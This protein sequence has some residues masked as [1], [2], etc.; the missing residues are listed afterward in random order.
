MTVVRVNKK[1]ICIFIPAL[2]EASS[3]GKVIDGFREQGYEN[4]LVVDGHSTDGTVDVARAHEAKVLVQDGRGKGQAIQQTFSTVSEDYI[5]MMDGDMTY[6]PSEVGLVLAPVLEGEADHVIGNRFANYQ[7]GAFTRLNLLGNRI[8]NRMFGLAHGVWLNDILSGYRAFNRYAIEKMELSEKGFEI[9][10]EMTVES[11]KK[12]VRITEVPITYCTR[13]RGAKTKLK[14]VRHGWRIGST[15]IRL[16]R[17]SNPLLFVGILGLLFV[18]AG[19]VTGL[20]VLWEW[21]ANIEHMPLTVLTSLS[22]IA[23]ILM[24]IF[25]FMGAMIVQSHREMLREMRNLDVKLRE[26]KKDNKKKKG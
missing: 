23:G 3:I 12:G 16:A 17:K 5:V 20:Y 22:I 6:L 7:A 2:N 21:L 11:I 4:I 13:V 15:I 26:L 10:S 18:G 24:V 19:V 1:N 9:E 8:L 14:P 25:G